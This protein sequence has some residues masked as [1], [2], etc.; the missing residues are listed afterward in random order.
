VTKDS[1]TYHRER[2]RILRKQTD[3]GTRRDDASPSILH[4]GDMSRWPSFAAGQARRLRKGD[5]VELR[6]PTEILA[7]LDDGGCLDGVPFM[8]EMLPYLGGRFTVAARVERACDTIG[9]SGARRMP[10]TVLLDD[11]RCNGTGHDGCQ[12]GCRLY[13][14]EAWLRRVS[15]NARRV[16]HPPGDGRFALEQLARRNTRGARAEGDGEVETY[17][18]QATEFLRAT[19]EIGWWDARSWMG[20]VAC[21]N[22][23]LVRFLR[24]TLRAVAE[25]ILRRLGL[26]SGHPVKDHG[27]AVTTEQLD[28]KPGDLVQVR[29]KNEIAETLDPSGKTRGLWFDREML[30]YC[31]E[32]H[33]VKKRVE[34]LID[35]EPAG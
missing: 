13:W 30:P 22:V 4:N 24:V 34:R 5:T 29:S 23:G 28:L 32:T 16:A 31:G 6:T 21:R 19:E 35:I 17:R 9:S 3:E 11:L 8:P 2:K 33:T 26:F 7:T 1:A 15:A 20:E 27:G 14:K 12:A 10:D 18:C 25:E